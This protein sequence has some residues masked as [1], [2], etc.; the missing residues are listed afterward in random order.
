MSIL[1]TEDGKVGR[2]RAYFDPRRLTKQVVS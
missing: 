2:F 1:E